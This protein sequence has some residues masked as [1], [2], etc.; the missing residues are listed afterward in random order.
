MTCVLA[1]ETLKE[2]LICYNP[3]ADV[4]EVMG[5]SNIKC[6]FD[7]CPACIMKLKGPECPQCTYTIHSFNKNTQGIMPRIVTRQ[8][9]ENGN[10]NGMYND[11]AWCTGL[12]LSCLGVTGFIISAKIVG[13]TVMKICCK[14]TQLGPLW[15]VSSQTFCCQICL[16]STTIVS[17]LG[18][19]ISLKR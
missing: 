4:K 19:C 10:E 8:H 12:L 13:W 17:S 15:G 9:Y 14:P 18:C 2:C 1:E 6:S 7:M 16:G 11:L 5:C 3:I